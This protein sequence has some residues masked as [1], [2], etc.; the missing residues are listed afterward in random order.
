MLNVSPCFAVLKTTLFVQP[1]ELE[2]D[3][4]LPPG[5]ESALVGMNAWDSAVVA[6]GVRLA[7]LD[8]AVTATTAVVSGRPQ[9]EIFATLVTRGSAAVM[10]TTRA[11]G[12]AGTSLGSQWQCVVFF[13]MTVEMLAC[14][15]Q[16]QERFKVADQ[17]EGS[18]LDE[19]AAQ[20]GE[21]ARP[22]PQGGMPRQ[23]AGGSIPAKADSVQ[24]LNATL[25]P[26]DLPHYAS[27]VAHVYQ[28][29]VQ[30]FTA[31]FSSNRQRPRPA[32]EAPPPLVVLPHL[33]LFN[34]W[35]GLPEDNVAVFL[36]AKAG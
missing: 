20:G 15:L 14:P 12:L 11:E 29:P 18:Q 2:R 30:L 22:Q 21:A 27:W 10:W 36:P 8:A 31:T 23:A 17:K 33:L 35:K 1:H 6:L 32:P 25:A 7:A 28:R 3:M 5:S 26:A 24:T 16:M 34:T 4:G 13:C 19:A 9:A